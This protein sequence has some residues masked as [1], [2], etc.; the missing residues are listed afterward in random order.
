MTLGLIIQLVNHVYGPRDPEVAR[1]VI[2][3]VAGGLLV[4]GG[5]TSASAKGYSPWLGLLGI[6]SFVGMGVLLLI[7]NRDALRLHKPAPEPASTGEVEE[8]ETEG[9]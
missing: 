9:T 7:P 4:W 1:Q 3:F 8:D 2:G 5:S 6:L